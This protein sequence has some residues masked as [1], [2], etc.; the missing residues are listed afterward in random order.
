M[1]NAIVIYG[2]RILARTKVHALKVSHDSIKCDDCKCVIN[3]NNSATAS[4][5]RRN[6]IPRCGSCY[7]AFRKSE[8]IRLGRL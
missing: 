5:S 3:S 1:K 6:H 4:H 2:G 7:L 8:R